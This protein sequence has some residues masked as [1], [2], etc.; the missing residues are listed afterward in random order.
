MSIVFA[1]DECTPVEW[2]FARELLVTGIS[3][4]AG[5]GDV[6]V[7]PVDEGVVIDLASPDGTA[8]LIAESAAIT[9]FVAKMLHTVP[10][11]AEQE[12]STIDE[13]LAILCGATIHDHDSTIHKPQVAPEQG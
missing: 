1:V 5:V 8:R 12:F 9:R 10:L 6:Q 7:F 2:V 13:E 11:G 4:P 3:R